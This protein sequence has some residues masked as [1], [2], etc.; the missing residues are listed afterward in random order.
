VEGALTRDSRLAQALSGDGRAREDALAALRS[1]L[2]E[3]RDPA[4][5]QAARCAVESAARIALAGGDGELAEVLRSV[6]RSGACDWLV[7][8]GAA[9]LTAEIDPTRVT[10]RS[11]PIAPPLDDDVQAYVRDAGP[12]PTGP[13]MEGK[14]RVVALARQHGG[15]LHVEL[16]PTTWELART[17]QLALLCREETLATRSATWPWI[18]AAFRGRPATPGLAAV[19]AIVVTADA[20]V[21]LLR[22][23]ETVSY[24][25]GHWS[26]TFEEQ[27][28]PDD[29]DGD[30]TLARALVR[31][32]REECGLGAPRRIELLPPI[33]ELDSLNIAFPAVI[34]L[35][36]SSAAVAAALARAGNDHEVAGLAFGGVDAL[37][38]SASSPID[39]SPLHPAS[40]IRCLALARRRRAQG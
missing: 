32:L 36:E 30:A 6:A 21:V 31:G 9:E 39:V 37:R 23:A 40:E 19:H 7:T 34:E 12:Q 3:E 15:A 38:N 33:L 29:L 16:A 17:F 13:G 4:R 35:A 25:A 8:G 24:M 28:V 5:L 26:S 1:A 14:L 18:D 10:C 2:V 11:L 20:K 22:R 27:I